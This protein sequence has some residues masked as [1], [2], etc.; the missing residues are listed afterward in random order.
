[1]IEE[2]IANSQFQDALDLLTDL[3]DETVRYQRLVCLYGLGQ[4]Q[5]AKNEGMLAK[6]KASN[7]YYDVVSIYLATLK[8]LEEFEEAIDIVVEELSMPYIPYEYES[9]FNA[10][11]DEL[12]LAKK[13]ANEGI[14]RHNN[15]FSLDDMENILQRD[16]ANEDL[17]YMAIEQMEGMNIRRLLP[18]I[19]IFLKDD[20]KPSFAK[21]LLIELMID[22]EIDEEMVLVKNGVEYEINPSYAPMVLNQEVGEA[23]L[24][25]LSEVIEDENP[26]LY[27]LCFQFLNFYLYL[28]YPKYIDEFEY[29]AIAGAIHYYLASMQYIDVELEDMELFYNC[30]KEEILEKL[31]EIKQIEY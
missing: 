10:A 9:V 18:A 12:L 15:A 2:Y 1:M 20:S 19:R 29:R 14:E 27:N 13:E 30:D 28:M 16:I 25:L 22:Q 3:D 23:I 7:T 17:L 5:Q 24:S 6:I 11:Y 8:E 26:S 31:E 4:Y 21:S